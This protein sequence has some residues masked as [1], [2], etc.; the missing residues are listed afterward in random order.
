MK[1]STQNHEKT[2]MRTDEWLTPPSIIRALGEF[3]LDPCSPITRPWP[4]AKNH[5]T[6]ND[7]G[8]LL[9]WTGRVWMNPPYGNTMVNWLKKLANH[10]NGI[11]LTFARTETVAFQEHV[12]PYCMVKVFYSQRDPRILV[13]GRAFYPGSH[14]VN[15]MLMLLQKAELKASI[16]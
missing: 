16:F 1:K 6:I 7:N 12:F 13:R 15:K 14:T 3:D 10:G 2:T 9:P 8:L 5:Y 11:A 4:T